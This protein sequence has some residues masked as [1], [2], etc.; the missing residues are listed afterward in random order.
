[1]KETTEKLRQRLQ[2]SP[3]TRPAHYVLRSVKRLGE[4][5]AAFGKSLLFVARKIIPIIIAHS[6]RPVLF[7]R[8]HGAGDIVCTF[9][10]A[11]KIR[12]RHPGGVFIY[13]C[14]PDFSCLPVMAGIASLTTAT[15]FKPLLKYWAF[16]FSHI[17]EFRWGEDGQNYYVTD[18]FPIETYCR[19]H[20]VEPVRS[21]PRLVVRPEIIKQTEILIRTAFPAE[22]GPLIVFHTGPTW[23]I[24][25]WSNAHWC[26][27]I[28][29][30][31]AAGIRRIVRL[32]ASKN[33]YFGAMPADFIPG[34]FSLVDKL[35][36]EETIGLIAKADLLIGID[37]GL[38]HFAAS[39]QT[40]AVGIW[41]PTNPHLRF[42]DNAGQH[43]VV[44]RVNCQGCHHRLPCLH[45]ISGC[46]HDIECMKTIEAEEVFQACMSA[47]KVGSNAG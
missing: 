36:L 3:A 46:Q 7:H 29:L 5:L 33:A 9:P 42:S 4:E 32:G 44:S 15:D 37:S 41:G 12:E 40:P 10:A 16:L 6:R 39:V 25:E 18:D 17:Y 14:H 27:L 30:L 45:W 21:H 1:M 28:S 2:A 24:R 26:E 11:L 19:Q 20:G 23:P 47:L 8:W 35:N 38:L 31:Q 43:P 34:V 22:T 13:N